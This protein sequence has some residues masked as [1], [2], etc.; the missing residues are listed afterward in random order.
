KRQ[1]LAMRR[2][3]LVSPNF[4]L[5]IVE[6]AQEFAVEVRDRSWHKRDRSPPAVAH[7]DDGRMVDE[8][9]GDLER[10]VAVGCHLHSQKWNRYRMP[11]DTCRGLWK[12][13]PSTVLLSSSRK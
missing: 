10:A 6:H 11:A 12:C 9:K 5:E 8:I 4:D 7:V 1:P 13:V 3:E 2:A